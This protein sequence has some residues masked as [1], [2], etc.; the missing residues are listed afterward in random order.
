MPVAA[1][2]KLLCTC[3]SLEAGIQFLYSGMPELGSVNLA[4][5]GL[6]GSDTTLNESSKKLSSQLNQ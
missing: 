5:K 3:H 2:G 6:L 1:L 4:A